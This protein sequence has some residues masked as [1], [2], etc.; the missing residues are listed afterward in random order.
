ML[1]DHNISIWLKIIFLRIWD[2]AALQYHTIIHH[3]L[4]I[5]LLKVS[6]LISY[7]L[8]S[9][10]F[11]LVFRYDSIWR[12]L[13]I[14]WFI[15]TCQMSIILLLENNVKCFEFNLSSCHSVILSSCHPVILSS[16]HQV[17]LSSHHH[18]IMFLLIFKSD[19]KCLGELSKSFCFESYSMESH[20][21]LICYLLY[22]VSFLCSR[23]WRSLRNNAIID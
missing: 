3:H 15:I 9:F 19:F 13:L 14:H 10:T 1:V 12:M 7:L 8:Q 22:S 21:L 2:F 4:S 11:S 5:L 6:K 20:L 16:Y 23:F 18:V 17:F